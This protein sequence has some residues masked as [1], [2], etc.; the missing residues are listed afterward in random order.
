MDRNYVLAQAAITKY[1]RLG[2]LNNRHVFLAVLEAG[3]PE[4]KMPADLLPGE[5]P[6]PGLQTATFSL[7]PGMAGK[8]NHC[9][10]S[11]SHKD[12]NCATGLHL[13]DLI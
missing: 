3:K 9:V 2:G 6:L 1:H 5:S 13:Q 11:S 7:Y 12:T 10:S 4:M 8:R